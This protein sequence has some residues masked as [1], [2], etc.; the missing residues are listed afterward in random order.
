MS[1]PLT[2]DLVSRLRSLTDL[3]PGVTAIADE[4]LFSDAAN[5]IE[6]LERALHV[7]GLQ[8]NSSAEVSTLAATARR[9]LEKS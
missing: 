5:R 8:D 9:A 4:V 3:T 7:I 1:D 2:T 6:K